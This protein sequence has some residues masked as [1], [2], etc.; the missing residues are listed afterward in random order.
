MN[1]SAMQT[2]GIKWTEVSLHWTPVNVSAGF[3]LE[4]VDLGEVLV[5]LSDQAFVGV[6]REGIVVRVAPRDAWAPGFD[7]I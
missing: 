3:D 7:P 1:T 6:E 2:V 4:R 5:A